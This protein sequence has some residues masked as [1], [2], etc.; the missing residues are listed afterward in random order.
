VYA[1]ATGVARVERTFAGAYGR[2]RPPRLAA[3]VESTGP[4]VSAAAEDFGVAWTGPP[5]SLSPGGLPDCLLDGEIF[6]LESIARRVGVATG[7]TPEATLAAAYARLG[8]SLIPRLRGDF[9]LLLWDACSRSG[10][11][12][13]DQLGA[14]GL[15]IHVEGGR[16]WFASELASLLDAL[17]RAPAPDHEALLSWLAEG[18]LP[19][20]RTL[21]RGVVQV[22][23]AC[24]LRLRDGCWERARYWTPTFA[25]PDRLDPDEAA[26]ELH[27][28]V[29]VS[30][31]RR[32]RG[33][34]RAGV[35][36]SGGLDSGAVL[37]VASSVAATT[38]SSLHAYSAVFPG[39]PAMDESELIEVQAG[40]NGT[41]L[42]QMPV[43]DGSPLAAGLRYLDRWRAPLPVPGHFMW[44]PLLEMAVGE[45]AECML[46]GEV[47]DELFGTAALLLADRLRRGDV[48][49]A[50]WLARSFPGIGASPS[51]RL[52]LSLLGDYGLMPC[53]PA[54]MGRL[55][56][57][58]RHVPFWLRRSQA[59]RY[60]GP[61]PQPWRSL[62]GPRWWAQ[63]ADMVLRGPE[64]MGFFDYFRRRG[65][66]A[67]LPAHHPF[68][69][70]DLIERV[71]ALP[72]EH[73]FDPS[74][75]RPLLRRAMRGVVA[76][77][78]RLRPGKSQFSS[79]VLDRLAVGDRGALALLLDGKHA[80]VTAFADPG[81]MRSLV[82]GGPAGHPRGEAM[83]VMEVWR[84]ALAEG[85]LRSLADAD[86]T[87]TM[88]DESTVVSRATSYV[89]RTRQATTRRTLSS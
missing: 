12:A 57:G 78:V 41:P 1:P 73:G 15:F 22:P 50:V 87:R 80:E 14:G 27:Q 86:F 3:A 29:A 35:L 36:L 84:L 49:S 52:V 45:G 25:A 53:L 71:L 82:D 10:V 64:R 68:L 47:G 61:D 40:F 17:P 6:N 8:E 48:A 66:A 7:E 89:S 19:P 18:R 42:R 85:W 65:K 31:E 75:N 81:A 59:R 69:D 5:A 26:A 34:R 30:V 4:A 51:R 46:D 88:L 76:E 72:P 39:H 83:W 44:E 33:R 54:G 74:L 63:L 9:A 56:G 11:L 20:D 38:Q 58:R 32:L 67:R 60:D 37:G 2:G 21:Y 23:P 24:L 13:R 55:V 79:P 16:L 28:A 62:E 77:P 70:L 43:T